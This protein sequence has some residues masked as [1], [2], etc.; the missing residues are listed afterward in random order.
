MRLS[1][2]V[3]PQEVQGQALLIELIHQGCDCLGGV[4]RGVVQAD[5]QLACPDV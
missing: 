2:G 1:S 5:G 4:H 3:G